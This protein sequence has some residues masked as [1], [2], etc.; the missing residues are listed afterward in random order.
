MGARAVIE[1]VLGHD[2]ARLKRLA[3]R[4]TSPVWP[5]E[6]VRYELWREGDD[7]AAPAR[8]RRCAQGG[9]AE[10]R[11]G[12]DRLIPTVEKGVPCTGGARRVCACALQRR[13]R[14]R[15]GAPLGGRRFA[16]TSLRCSRRRPAAELARSLR[17]L[18]SNSCG[19]SV[20][21]ARLSFGRR[22]AGDAP[23]LGATEARRSGPAS[24]FAG[25][26]VPVS[27]NIQTSTQAL[28]AWD[29]GPGIQINPTVSSA[30]G[31]LR[32]GRFLGRRG[33]QSGGGRACRR[34]GALRNLTRRS[35]LS[36]VNRRDTQRVLRRRPQTSTA[37]ESARSDDRPSM[38][39]ARRPPSAGAQACMSPAVGRPARLSL[40]LLMS[41]GPSGARRCPH[42]ARRGSSAPASARPTPCR[43]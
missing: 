34:T 3:V 25:Y 22:A 33:A 17:S 28:G 35:C 23:L 31:G 10:Q 6:T 13:P 38:S 11:P 43:P 8:Q 16:P 32:A 21:E 5:G 40:P 12:R 2:A 20:H 15:C 24:T 39:P 1:K 26:V 41:R 4:F 19:K 36:G 29:R 7:A 30:E 37:A 18:R 9:R 42:T 14:V 27:P